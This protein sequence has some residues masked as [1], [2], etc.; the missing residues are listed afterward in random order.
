MDQLSVAVE[1][2]LDVVGRVHDDDLVAATFG[3]GLDR[4]A[5]HRAAVEL[6]QKLLRA[7]HA[8]AGAG[9]QHHSSDWKQ[10][11]GQPLARRPR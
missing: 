1:C 7:T 6:E 9:G 10:R 11:G 4:V 5:D 3:G 2:L 8:R